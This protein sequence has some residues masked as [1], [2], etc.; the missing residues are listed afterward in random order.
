MSWIEL[1]YR[2]PDPDDHKRVLVYTRHDF[3]GQQIFDVDTSDFIKEISSSDAAVPH[4]VYITATHWMPLPIPPDDTKDYH[5][6]SVLEQAIKEEAKFVLCFDFEN[7]KCSITLSSGLDGSDIK[8][9]RM[10][11]KFAR[12]QRRKW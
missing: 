3:E 7:P 5:S 12:G 1:P 11:E 4:L 10:L 6:L 2:M 8:T 9:A